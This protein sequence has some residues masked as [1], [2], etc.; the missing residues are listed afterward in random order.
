MSP[1]TTRWLTSLP[2][3]VALWVG[4]APAARA[5]EGGFVVPPPALAPAPLPPSEPY[6][7]WRAGSNTIAFN[8]GIGS[9]VGFAGFT[10]SHLFGSLLETELGVG[11]GFTGAQLS[12]MQKI[13]LGLGHVRFVPGLG[14]AYS[15]GGGLVDRSRERSLWLNFDVASVEV[16]TSGHFV[17]FASIGGTHVIGE[18]VELFSVD[19]AESTTACEGASR[20]FVQMR[21]GFGGS[22]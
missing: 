21:L 15:P 8:L 19:C 20:D 16:R 7:P 5:G 10:Y 12:V 13:A 17:F 11:L 18:P 6:D 1:R 2:L 4:G 9:A 3:A 14:L 22:F